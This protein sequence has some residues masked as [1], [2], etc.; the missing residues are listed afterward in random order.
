MTTELI[1]SIVIAA[2][3]WIWAIIQFFTNRRWQKKDYVQQQRYEA[4][5]GFMGKM[6]SISESMRNDPT[7]SV[8]SMIKEFMASLLASITSDSFD[9]GTA[10]LTF[11]NQLL[12]QT[13]KSC[14]PLQQINGEINSI[15]LIASDDLLDKL[16]E[17]QALNQDL[18]NEMMLAL[19]A[20]GKEQIPDFQELKTVG[21]QERWKRFESLY[22]EI[23]KI[24]RKEI[25]IQ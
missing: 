18:Y 1:I 10:T 7:K 20:V 8:F 25:G 19:K 2:A 5:K 11:T 4:Y 12:D 21:Q 22:S 9:A 14:E 16:D 13:Q 23:R 24:M 3:G 17:L 15:K 6:D